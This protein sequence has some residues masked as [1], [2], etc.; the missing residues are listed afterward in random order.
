MEITLNRILRTE[1]STIGE[2]KVNGEHECWSLEDRDRGL[3][4]N[5]DKLQISAIKVHGKTAI[6]T[7]RYQVVITFSNRFKKPLPLLLNVPGFEGIR[8]HPGNTEADSSGC[9]LTGTSY[10]T[11]RVNNSRVAF[12]DLFEKIETAAKTEKIYITIQ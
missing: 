6:P 2:I 10:D 12:Y 1:K 11:D 4:Q 7:G 8:I 9:I 5:T 3:T